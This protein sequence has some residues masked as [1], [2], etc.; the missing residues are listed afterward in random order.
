MSAR[1]IGVTGVPRVSLRRPWRSGDASAS[2]L[3]R[4][5][6][7]SLTEAVSVKAGQRVF[8]GPELSS[9]FSLGYNRSMTFKAFG[10]YA[11]GSAWV[12]LFLF[13]AE[14]EVT[15][16]HFKCRTFDAA[17][18]VIVLLIFP[19]VKG[20]ICPERR[21]KSTPSKYASGKLMLT[22]EKWSGRGRTSHLDT[23][24]NDD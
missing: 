7:T 5:I 24:G 4:W 22:R 11:L 6:S 8:G 15:D 9:S 17:D 13:Q 3:Y 23:T 16:E 18:S 21:G 2:P 19:P 10:W 20:D 14:I 1:F 12:S